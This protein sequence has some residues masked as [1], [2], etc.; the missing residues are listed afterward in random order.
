MNNKKKDAVDEKNPDDCVISEYST[1]GSEFDPCG[2]I[3][4]LQQR[5]EMVFFFFL[6]D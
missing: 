6:L 4:D 3:M 1:M 5:M 2:K